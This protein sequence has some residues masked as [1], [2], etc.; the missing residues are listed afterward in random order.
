MEIQFSINGGIDPVAFYAALLS[1]A[2]AVWEYVKWRGRNYLEVNCNANMLFL[3]SSDK[4]KYI[5][6][7]ATNK[8]QTATTITHLGLYYWENRFKRIFKRPSQIYMIN[9]DTVPKVINPGEQWMG[10]GEQTA[11]VEQMASEGLLYAIVFHSMG[12]KGILRRIKISKP[13]LEKKLA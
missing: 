1:T 11:E 5:V 7:R 6:A 12:K 3:P 13:N 8:G 10:Q 4:K 2:I 9:T